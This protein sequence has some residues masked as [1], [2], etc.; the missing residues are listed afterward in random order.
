MFV[1]G[2][3]G[4]FP[5]NRITRQVQGELAPVGISSRGCRTEVAA[6]LDGLATWAC[7]VLLMC[8]LL[9][10]IDGPCGGPQHQLV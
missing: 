5:A 3:V 7:W 8:A 6:D 2:G 1:W 10:V 9:A 4:A